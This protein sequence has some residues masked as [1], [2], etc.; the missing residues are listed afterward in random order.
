MITP[1][2]TIRRHGVKGLFRGTNAQILA[3]TP[4]FAVRFGVYE[5]LARSVR[6]LLPLTL[7]LVSREFSLIGFYIALVTPSSYLS[8]AVVLCSPSRSFRVFRSIGS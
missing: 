2:Q 3:M 5:Y 1:F 6:Q 7:R 4:C 8:G